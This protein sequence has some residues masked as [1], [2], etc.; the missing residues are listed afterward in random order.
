MYFYHAVIKILN[1]WLYTPQE[2]FI[3]IEVCTA[4]LLSYPPLC[5]VYNPNSIESLTN[6]PYL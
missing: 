1:E 3:P 5:T 6:Y 2:G 4:A